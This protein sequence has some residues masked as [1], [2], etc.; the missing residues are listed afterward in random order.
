MSRAACILAGLGAGTL[1]V[2]GLAGPAALGVMIGG[3]L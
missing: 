2:L 1:L 3:A